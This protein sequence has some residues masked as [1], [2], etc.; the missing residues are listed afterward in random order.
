M[1]FDP[2]DPYTPLGDLPEDE[3]GSLALI[4]NSTTDALTTMP[5]ISAELNRLDRTVEISLNPNGGIA[6]TLSEKTTGQSAVIERSRLKRLSA[7]DYNRMI[8][9]WLSR[10]ATGAKMT[11]IETKDNSDEGNFNLNIEFSAIDYA[12]LM[13]GRLMVFK[14]AV[15][16]RLDRLSFTDGK[17]FHPYV[18]EA[19]TYSENVRVKLPA[20]FA[21]DEI[22][23]ATDLETAFGKYSTSYSVTGEYLTF[24]RSMKLNRSTIPADRYETVRSFFGRVR[25][26]EQSPVVL[27]RK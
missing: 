18:I 20:G 15:V 7:A 14:P 17:R 25:A 24:K 11:K 3:Q 13:Q 16:S 10:G 19:S 26:A 5:V 21:V 23:E 6:G 2:T 9:G 22:P 27:V 1:I 4:D 12:Q 8:E